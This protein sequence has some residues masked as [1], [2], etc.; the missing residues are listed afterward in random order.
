MQFG[1]FCNL[2]DPVTGKPRFDDIRGIAIMGDE[3]YA[4]AIVRKDN[5]PHIITNAEEMADMVDAVMITSHRG[6]EHLA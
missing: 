1:K 3:I 5:I 2:P 4:A 6:S